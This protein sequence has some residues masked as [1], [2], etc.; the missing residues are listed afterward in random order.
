LEPNHQLIGLLFI[1]P[2][3]ITVMSVCVPRVA[4]TR[5]Q[6]AVETWVEKLRDD[7]D[8]H[9]SDDDTD[10][11]DGSADDEDTAKNTGPLPKAGS[12]TQVCIHYALYTIHYALYTIHCTLYTKHSYTV[13]SYTILMHYT[14][15]YTIH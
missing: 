15:H 5:V 1:E 7:H 2:S 11:D 3:I 6:R 13:H 8:A 4:F 12:E 14:L 10:S 9:S